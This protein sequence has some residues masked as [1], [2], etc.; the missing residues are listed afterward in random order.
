MISDTKV[1]Y[2]LFYIIVLHLVAII[3]EAGF[4]GDD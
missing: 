3:K 2:I 4:S 1:Y